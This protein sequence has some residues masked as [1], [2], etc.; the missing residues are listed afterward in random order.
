MRI[1]WFTQCLLSN[2]MNLRNPRPTDRGTQFN[3][4]HAQLLEILRPI[5]FAETCRFLTIQLLEFQEIWPKNSLE[6][7]WMIY[8]E[9]SEFWHREFLI[10]QK[11]IYGELLKS[12]MS[13]LEQ[14]WQKGCH[15][16]SLWANDDKNLTTA[17]FF[18]K[19][20]PFLTH[21]H[22]CTKV[23]FFS[24]FLFLYKSLG[25]HPYSINK[26]LSFHKLDQFLPFIAVTQIFFTSDLSG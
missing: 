1:N 5:A 18:N 17:F 12:P 6:T 2:E 9:K 4:A 24:Y 25:S 13:K 26:T 15:V 21:P 14:C 11:T 23:Y 16:N 3:A 19:Q 8:H 20:K 7:T 22:L 10:V